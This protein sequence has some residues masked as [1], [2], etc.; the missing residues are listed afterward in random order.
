[1]PSANLTMLD[2]EIVK[3]I[4]KDPFSDSYEKFLAEI[5]K[6]G[7]LSTKE[8]MLILIGV[9]SSKGWVHFVQDFLSEQI[10]SLN[11]KSEEIMEIL[12]AVVLSRGVTPLIDGIELLDGLVGSEGSIGRGAEAP[13]LKS[14]EEIMD[15][16]RIRFSEVPAWIET[17]GKK[18][19]VM[20]QNYHRM[21]SNSVDEVLLPRRVKE[22][23]LV[24]VNA[25]G[26]YDEGMRIH[27]NGA[28]QSGAPKEEILEALLVAAI[29][30]GI[31]SWIAGITVMKEIKIL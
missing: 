26:L 22:L 4:Q 27:M 18:F 23:V 11:I 29:V 31:V 7:L 24:A 3:P 28:L 15:Y 16:F 19:P 25:A 10:K 9:Y 8:K 13:N 2:G 21:R 20:L 1:M 17:L 12:K 6:E 14:A 5:W 30:G